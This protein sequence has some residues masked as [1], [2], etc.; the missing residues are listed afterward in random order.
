MA[1]STTASVPGRTAT[2]DG[3]VGAPRPAPPRTGALARRAW[4]HVRPALPAWVAA[5]VVVALSFAAATLVR[6]Y[7]GTPGGRLAEGVRAWDAR[8]YVDIAREGYDHLPRVGVRFFPLL[9]V[10]GRALSV[11]TGGDTTLGVV[12]VANASALALG[13]LLHR[14][15]LLER[16]DAALG[17]RAAWLVAFTPAAF[18]LVWGYA[19]ALAGALAV[20][21]FLALR[22]QRWW[23]AAV[24]GLLAGLTR[25]VGMLLALPAAIEAARG[26]RSATWPDRAARMAAVVSPV[27]GCG[28][29]LAWVEARYGTGLLPLTIQRRADFRGD[30]VSPL[31][32]LWD[33]GRDLLD[34]ELFGN[35]GHVPWALLLIALVVV[36]FRH[37][38]VSYGA[39]AAASLLVALTAERLGSLE[40][41]GFGAFPVV[42]T[43]A[44]LGRRE[45]VER[46][47]LA[48][49][50]AAMLGYGTLALLGVYV[51]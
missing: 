23:G 24:A 27:A 43:L 8:W 14:L 42:L 6:D 13:A 51:P 7:H 16:G 20:A 25:P 50:A 1:R 46:A 38:P 30:P 19:E 22:T 21:M 34:G 15:C 3:P 49:G 45:G 47:T 29:Y 41:Y 33:G 31:R 44:V 12:L 48:V 32:V 11:L 39:F 5:R 4:A 10:L 36:T 17:R 28:L 40:R 26:L 2:G 35:A 9:P 18:V 37:W